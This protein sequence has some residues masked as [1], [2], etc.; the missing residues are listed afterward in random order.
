MSIPMRVRMAPSGPEVSRVA[1]GLWRLM[2]VPGGAEVQQVLARIQTCLDHGITTFDHAD[3]YGGYQ[4]EAAFGAALRAH[5]GLRQKMELVTKCG[6]MLVNPARPNNRL[7]HYDYS[8]RH[9]VESVESSLR[10]LAT[11][12]LDVLLLHRPSPML[13][14][15]EVAEALQQLVGQGK[16]R[17]LGVSNFTPSQFDM[18]ASR[19]TV[20]LVTNQV[21]IHPLRL[22]A[23]QDG[24]LDQCMRAR[25]SPMAWSPLAGGRLATGQGEA[26]TRVRAVLAELARRYGADQEQFLLAWLLRH[27]SRI[28]PV[29]GT[30]RLERIT[31]AAGALSLEMELQDWFAIWSAALGSE[32]P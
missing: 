11:D 10:N 17:H 23:F 1:Y 18:L 19:L 7:K 22:A 13:D 16:V 30:N 26:E 15:D 25:I 9:I 28:I 24:T 21:E 12:H 20:S 27:P 32:V 5:P 2:A 14:P 8:R 29:V 31:S 6:I 3:I 4:C